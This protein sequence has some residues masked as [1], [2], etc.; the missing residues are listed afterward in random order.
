MTLVVIKFEIQHRDAKGRTIKELLLQYRQD[1]EDLRSRT[2]PWSEQTYGR[3]NQLK[4]SG[5]EILNSQVDRDT[6]AI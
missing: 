6:L 4:K 5:I 1:L 3:I 2:K